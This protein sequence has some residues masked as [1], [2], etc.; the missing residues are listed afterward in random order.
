MKNVSDLMIIRYSYLLIVLIFI[1]VRFF[2]GCTELPSQA[3][4]PD[5]PL[6]PNNPNNNIQGPAL[7]LSPTE[8]NI[9][10][11]NDFQLELWIV[12]ADSM[13][14][15]STRI[16]FDPLKF[17]VEEI[18]S[19]TVNSESFLLQN[20]G[21]LIFFSNIDNDS[22]FIDIDCAVV[23]GDPRN[24]TGSGLI[25]RMNFN[26][27]TGTSAKLEISEESLLRDDANEEQ[28]IMDRLGSQIKIK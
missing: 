26:H 23:E 24:V 16:Y 17:S 13:A 28:N 4:G 2:T 18:D 9:K 3:E 6:D 22:G 20:G 15:L 7:I 19:L 8:V 14:G 1:A 10:A 21:Q 12:D 5:N 11:G 27:L 25:S